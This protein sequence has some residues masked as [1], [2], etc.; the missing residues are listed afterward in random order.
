MIITKLTIDDLID[1]IE[2]GDELS[3]EQIEI[4]RLILKC[5][6]LDKNSFLNTDN[7]HLLKDYK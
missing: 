3:S 6:I 7:Q 4:I 2:T 1:Q 5:I